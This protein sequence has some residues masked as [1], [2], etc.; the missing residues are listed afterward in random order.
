VGAAPPVRQ[1]ARQA[2]GPRAQFFPDDPLDCDDPARCTRPGRGAWQFFELLA[3]RFGPRTVRALYDRSST[4]G[5]S[6]HRPHFREALDDVLAGA[7]T[8]LAAT[9][10]EFTAANLVGDYALQGLA[11]RRY[12]ATEPYDDLATGS[13]TR[14]FRARIV[15]LDHLSAAFYRLRSGSDAA[16]SRR[17]I[18]RRAR[19]RVT[20]DGPAD[21]EEPLFWAPFRPHGD[22][23]P[24]PLV[25][26]RT[27]IERPWTTCTG[28]ELGVALQNPSGTVDARRFR[29]RVELTVARR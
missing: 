26:G 9:F 10:A 12:G 4:L 24:V 28:R 25:K 2:A 16:A 14:R 5:A 21:L 27:T 8:T 17:P 22:V 11:R 18:C 6:D 1:R 13:R 20:I 23:R 29:L 7:Q 15:K 3:E 19:L